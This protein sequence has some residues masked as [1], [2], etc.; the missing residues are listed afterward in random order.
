MVEGGLGTMAMRGEDAKDRRE[1]VSKIGLRKKVVTH[2]LRS[3]NRNL[4]LNIS[5]HL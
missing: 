3:L 1:V 5:S 4:L 2:Y